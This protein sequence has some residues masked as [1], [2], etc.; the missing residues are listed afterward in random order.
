MK[1]TAGI[2]LAGGQSRRFGSPKAFA[3]FEGAPFYHYSLEALKPFC[4][5][6][7]VVTRPE[8]VDKFPEDLC[9]TTDLTQFKGM[10]PLAGILSGMEVVEA[11]CYIVLPCDMP[12]MQ[13]HVIERL[14][15]E[16]RGEVSAVMVEGKRHPLV[17]I[18]QASVKPAIRQALFEDNRRVMHVQAQLNGQWV[19]GS[20]LTDSPQLVFKNVNTPCEIERR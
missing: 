19:E 4:E 17:S 3:E 18:W 12:F 16:H 2:L 9:V 7:I 11:D 8:F 13:Q 20:S 14:V 6:I 15:D 1:R 5:E 10:G